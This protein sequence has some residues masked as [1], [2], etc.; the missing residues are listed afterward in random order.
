MADELDVSVAWTPGTRHPSYMVVAAETEG[1]WIPAP[2]YTW[3]NDP[4]EFPSVVWNPGAKHPAKPFVAGETEG[5]W[6]P[7]PG[8]AAQ[9]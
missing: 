3:A 6:Q 2:G 1:H 8:Y 5:A 7:A 4:P 9:G